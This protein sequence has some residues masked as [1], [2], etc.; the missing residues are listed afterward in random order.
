MAENDIGGYRLHLCQM[1]YT[2]EYFQIDHIT[3]ST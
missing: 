2:D 1:S 3:V